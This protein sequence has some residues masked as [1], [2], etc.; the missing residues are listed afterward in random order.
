[1]PTTVRGDP[2]EERL[3]RAMVEYLQE[4]DAGRKPDRSEFLARYPDLETELAALLTDDAQLEVLIPAR[5]ISSG[6]GTFIS[7]SVY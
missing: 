4:V 3:E 2:Q 7:V 5:V 6:A 1:M